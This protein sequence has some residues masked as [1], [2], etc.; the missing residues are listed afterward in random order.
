[1][2]RCSHRGRRCASDYQQTLPLSVMWFGFVHIGRSRAFVAFDRVHHPPS[3][4]Y[5]TTRVPRRFAQQFVDVRIDNLVKPAGRCS[6]ATLQRPATAGPS[7][8]RPATA[9]SLA[10]CRCGNPHGAPQKSATGTCCRC[11]SAPARHQA[12]RSAPAA[13]LRETCRA[14]TSSEN[15][16]CAHVGHTWEGRGMRGAAGER[17]RTWLGW[18]AVHVQE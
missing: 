9:C 7:S 8:S 4:P 10:G 18:R 5:P 12:P 16:T 17:E 11:R 3:S 14:C 13:E 1:M 15:C 6:S 2:Q